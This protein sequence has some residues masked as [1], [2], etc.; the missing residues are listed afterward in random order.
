MNEE[1]K[2]CLRTVQLLLCL[3]VCMGCSSVKNKK[4]SPYE[5]TNLILKIILSENDIPIFYQRIKEFNLSP[6]N[7]R[8]A[9]I[10]SENAEVKEICFSFQFSNP[11]DFLRYR[12]EILSIGIVR[13]IK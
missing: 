12:S 7:A 2:N 10:N 13:Q 1:I 11:T 5:K 9:A 8:Y 6:I 4:Y 3:F